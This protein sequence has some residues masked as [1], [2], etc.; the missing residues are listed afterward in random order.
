MLKGRKDGDFKR[1]VEKKRRCLAKWSGIKGFGR[2]VKE[3]GRRGERRRNK[4]SSAGHSSHGPNEK[5]KSKN[6]QKSKMKK[7]CENQQNSN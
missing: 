6:G 1:A 7:R 4:E 5:M 3:E 2:G